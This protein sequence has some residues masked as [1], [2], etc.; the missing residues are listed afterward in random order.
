MAD[1]DQAHS[2]GIKPLKF[3]ETSPATWFKVME[4]Q[5]HI[6][7]I[8]QSQTKFFYIL[9]ALSTDVLDNVPSN[10]ID[11]EDYGELKDSIISF[12]EK[13]KPE[14]F[15]KLISSTTMTGRPSAY[16]RQLQQI[17]AK[18]NASDDL[19]R[20]KFLQGLPPTIAHAVGAQLTLTLTQLGGVADELMPLHSQLS[21]VNLLSDAPSRSEY[22]PDRRRAQPNQHRNQPH[23]SDAS[24]PIAVRPFHSQQRTKICRTHLYFAE[25][26]KYCK[27]WCRY[28][29]KSNCSMQPSS[30]PGSRHSSPQRHHQGNSQSELQWQ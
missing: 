19:V 20:H 7:K 3:S 9:S 27:P 21:N 2:V 8:T 12:Y 23:Q 26:A 29:D 28:P 4:A 18:V 1:E 14:L 22:Q 30:R 16:L 17:A 5:F 13:T 24:L 25:N 11:K 6:R 10:L 15:E